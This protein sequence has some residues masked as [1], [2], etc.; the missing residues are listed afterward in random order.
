MCRNGETAVSRQFSQQPVDAQGSGVEQE[1]VECAGHVVAAIH[2]KL[3]AENGRFVGNRRKQGIEKC[4]KR[5]ALAE[6]LKQAEHV[7]FFA[8]AHF[9]G[10]NHQ[11]VKAVVQ[12][13]IAQGFGVA[14]GVVV[15]QCN[16]IQFLE[17]GHAGNVVWS[18]V[19]VTAGG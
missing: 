8:G 19:A 2:Q 14:G 9:N 3:F 12:Y 11:Q 16:D 7:H 17:R 1:L 10:R 6:V 18:H 13:G 4:V 5:F 15:G